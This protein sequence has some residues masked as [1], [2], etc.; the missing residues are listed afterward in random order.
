[1][2][3]VLRATLLLFA[4]VGFKLLRMRHPYDGYLSSL[5]TAN[6]AEIDIY[7]S[8]AHRKWIELNDVLREVALVLLKRVAI[9]GL[10]ALFSFP[11]A[12]QDALNLVH[13]ASRPRDDA[14]V[15]HA[16]NPHH[17]LSTLDALSSPTST[18]S[19][20]TGPASRAEA[21]GAAAASADNLR[22]VLQTTTVEHPKAKFENVRALREQFRRRAEMKRAM[23][24]I[25]P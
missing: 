4:T 10:P 3:S 19:F 9:G 17:S 1:M 23:K 22:G 20:F 11:T 24:K 12:S 7:F 13:P 8:N 14:S 21:V 16:S 15:D 18:R 6:R 2:S 5:F 25:P